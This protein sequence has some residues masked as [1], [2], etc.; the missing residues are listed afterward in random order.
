MRASIASARSR[1]PDH[2]RGAQLVHLAR[3]DV[4]DD[5]DVAD[6]AGE[7][8]LHRRRVVAG[9][10]GEPVL[11]ALD[12][13]TD[14]L[15]GAERLL[16]ADDAGQAGQA[17]AGL[18]RHVERRAAGHV[19]EDLGDVDGAGDRL[20]VAEEPLLRRLVVVGRD[21]Q[22]GVGAGRPRVARQLDRL[23][24]GVRPGAGDDRYPPAHVAH[25]LADDDGVLGH[26]QRRRLPG[27]AD[28]DDRVGALLDVELDEGGERLV[29]DGA[30]VE[31]RGDQRHHAALEHF[32]TLSTCGR[33]G[34]DGTGLSQA[35]R[36][37]RQR[38]R[39]GVSALHSGHERTFRRRHRAPLRP[40][41]HGRAARLARRPRRAHRRAVVLPARRDAGLHERGAGLHGAGGR[42]R[43]GRRGHPRAS[44]R[45]PSRATRSSAR[46][47]ACRS[48][49]C[50][51]RAATSA[52]PTT[53]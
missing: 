48:I 16:D 41:G 4:G 26:R 14:A 19:V 15:D 18:G 2:R 25:D 8:A 47:T 23:G 5:G 22:A 52:A 10:D 7:Q 3:H 38:S 44:R 37:S 33:H 31:H 1:S 13:V 34:T 11:A 50:P 42:V 30:V 17:R 21:E 36:M 43:G 28:R 24:R 32:R 35:G 46:S 40:P 12:E 51:T 27:G 6:T 9:D 49:C 39:D 53:C 20:E 45:T 29:V